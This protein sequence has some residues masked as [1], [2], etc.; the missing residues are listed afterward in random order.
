MGNVCWAIS[1]FTNKTKEGPT[2]I[3]KIQACIDSGVVPS[4]IEFLD[5]SYDNLVVAS[6]K[7]IGNIANGNNQQ[8]AYLISL[9]VLDKL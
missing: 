8:G 6:L 5:H 1:Y 4:V 9:N 7:T 2:K 3:D